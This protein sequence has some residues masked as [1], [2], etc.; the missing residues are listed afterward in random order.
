MTDFSERADLVRASI[1][2]WNSE[3]WEIALRSVW[4]PE[5]VIVTPEGWPEP[6]T[7]AGWEAMVEQWGR[8]KGSW[9]KERVE[10]ITAEPAGEG[11]LAEVR[12]TL[13]GEASGAPLEVRVWLLCEL[14]G[15]RLSRMTY[16]LDRDAARRAAE[17][18]S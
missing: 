4:R 11:V 8:V 17:E 7:F 14:T 10:L 1:D 12:W 3:D 16:F 6:G 15:D 2:A 13:Q 18:L 5:G 9:A